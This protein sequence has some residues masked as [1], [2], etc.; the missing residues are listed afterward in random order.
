MLILLGVST[1]YFA[2]LASMFL[3]MCQPPQRFGQVM[4]YVPMPVMSVL[5]FEA[6]WNVARGGTARIGE[7]AP[8]FDL[9]TIDRKSRVVLSSLRG[10]Q[11][12]V[13]VFGSYT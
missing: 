9:P 6:M 3:V 5:P 13:L 10:K 12:V 8:D 1:V 2:F 11:P 7:M 4:A